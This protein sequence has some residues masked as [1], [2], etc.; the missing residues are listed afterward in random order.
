MTHPGVAVA[1]LDLV[2][3]LPQDPTHLARGR[4]M[5]VDA[6]VV[7]LHHQLRIDADDLAALMAAGIIIWNG[8]PLLRRALNELMDRS[9][10]REVI[11]RIRQIAA[12]V[13]GVDRIEKCLVRKMGYYY[14][15]DMHV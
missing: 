3:V 4:G 13:A 15:V 14:Y 9:P 2:E 11:E 6:V 12:L 7:G 10:N 1:A 8:W 5:L